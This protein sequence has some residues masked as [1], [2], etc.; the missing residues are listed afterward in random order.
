MFVA[1]DPTSSKLQ[2]HR[3]PEQGGLQV[4]IETMSFHRSLGKWS[5]LHG[6]AKVESPLTEQQLSRQWSKPT[7]S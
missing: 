5:Q 7:V 4:D 1:A 3:P 2:P 6:H